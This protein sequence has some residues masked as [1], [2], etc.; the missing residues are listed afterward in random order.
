MAGATAEVRAVTMPFVDRLASAV[1]TAVPPILLAVGIGLGVLYFRSLWW[2]TRLFARG[3][4]PTTTIAVML[5][6]FALLGAVLALASLEGA[7]PLLVLTLGI[8]IARCAVMRR[9]REAAP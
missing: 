5:G 4:R 6:R 2:N 9:V 7:M 1:I 8:L 3:G